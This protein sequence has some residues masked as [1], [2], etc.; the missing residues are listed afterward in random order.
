MNHL[1]DNEQLLKDV[2]AEESAAGFRE[3][4]LGETLRQA[5]SRRRRRLAQRLT[6]VLLVGCMAAWLLPRR[7]LPVAVGPAFPICAGC[8]TISSQ[9]LPAAMI[10]STQPIQPESMVASAAMADVLRTITARGGYRE[11]GDDELLALSPEPA[12]LVRR[13]PHQAELVFI[14]A[15]DDDRAEEN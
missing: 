1:P 7:P 13:G 9:P 14:S 12:A 8:E 15:T 3:A 6:G 11:I 4:L 10:V 5:R 2:L